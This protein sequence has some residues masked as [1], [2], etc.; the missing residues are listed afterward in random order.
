MAHI[1]GNPKSFSPLGLGCWQYN[2]SLWSAGQEQALLD[3]M[4]TALAHG[5]DH[6]DTA[7]GYGDGASEKLVGRFL[8]G[9]RSQ[10]FVATKA[11]IQDENPRTMLE[12]VK[13]SLVRLDTDFIDLYYIHWP[14]S[15]IDIRPAMEGLELARAQRLVRAV[16]VSNFSV[17][18]MEL[19]SQVGK[20]DAHQ[21]P[22]SLLWRARESDVIPFCRQHGIGVI[23]YGV[24]GYG[25][26]TGKFNRKPTFKPEDDRSH[27]ILF[28]EEPT[29]GAIY[30]A[31]EQMKTVAQEVQRPLQHLAIRWSLA[32]L[33]IVCALAG[34]NSP[35]Q[36]V[37]NV[38]ALQGELPTWALDRLTEISEALKKD[39]PAEANPN[40]F[41]P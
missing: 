35:A 14:R 23:A 1:T 37:Q 11:G 34:A 6:F 17:A 8:H 24:M 22:H 4:D 26:L 5:M 16:G 3:T 15:D 25:I 18:Q 41:E 40:K 38:A 32:Q 10:V 12:S 30:A 7:T 33:G 19:V 13:A 9:R 29:W 20:I 2:P 21:I 31:V 27:R 28:F 39:I 36:A